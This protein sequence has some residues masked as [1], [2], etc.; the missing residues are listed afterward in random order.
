MAAY[1]PE[2]VRPFTAK[3]DLV[4]VVIA[5][6]VNALQE[7]VGAIE[8]AL[9][10]GTTTVQSPFYSAFTGTFTTT[11]NATSKWA[12]LGDRLANIEAGLV[13]GVTTAPYVLKTGGSII[14][15]ATNKAL[16]LKTGTGTLSLFET[17]TSASVLGFNVD[18]L[19]I[20]K[21]GTANVLYVGNTD[22]NTLVSATS[23][24]A[25]SAA[26]KIPLSTVTTVGDLIVGTGSATVGR[27]AIGTNG[28][29]LLSNGTTAVWGSPLDAT[30]IPLSTVT[31][32][33][34]LLLGTG[35]STIGRLGIGT[36]GQ[37]LTSNG[38][39]ATWAAPAVT[40]TQLST[41]NSAVAT[42]QA[43]ADAKIPLSTV[44]TAGDL[45]LG[46]GASTVGRLARGSSGQA[47]I[48]SGTSV[49]W[50]APVDATKI[51]LSTVT[52]AGDLIVAT[53]AS[54]VARLAIGANGQVLTSN[55]TTTTWA[56][57]VSSYVSQTNGAVTTAA[58]GSAVVRNIHATT[59]A[60]PATS[61]DGDIWV[62]YA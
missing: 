56:T 52:T 38:T 47:L 11:M 12:T 33:G 23:T 57:P 26:T 54:T 8:L 24:A 61:I 48:M 36:N 51:P 28:Q 10:V 21:V 62:V 49:V 59:G 5:D 25:S 2:S 35:T 9:G 37:I 40:A 44:T 6:H 19:G 16:T 29:S 45:I 3:I 53:A 60:T 20:P 1:F 31:A 22:Y 18:Y 42:A 43:A 39:T 4:N 34:D 55:G 14:T 17:L 27:L 41:T 46:T 30:K 32:A 7:E 13:N 50:G 15:T 58:V